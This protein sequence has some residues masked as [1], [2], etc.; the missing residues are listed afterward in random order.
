MPYSIV[1]AFLP[2]FLTAWCTSGNP[3]DCFPLGARALFLCLLVPRSVLQ[4]ISPKDDDDLDPET[5]ALTD[6]NTQD[7][8]AHYGTARPS[9][10]STRGNR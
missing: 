6:P 5:D 3:T 10:S 8:Q 2:F 7:S 1:A 4:S 9:V